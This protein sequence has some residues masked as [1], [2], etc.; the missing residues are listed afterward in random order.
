MMTIQIRKMTTDDLTLGLRLSRQAGWNQ[1]EA[2]WSRLMYFE[3]EGCFVAELDGSN[4]IRDKITGERN[5]AEE[6]GISLAR[7]LLSSGADKILERI[8]GKA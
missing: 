3:P 6:M 5:E 8:Y 7:R 1:T 2:D 4:V